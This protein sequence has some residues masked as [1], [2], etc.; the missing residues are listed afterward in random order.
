MS[1][2]KMT[3]GDIQELT[4]QVEYL[5]IALGRLYERFPDSERLI[6][7]LENASQRFDDS[8]KHGMHKIE[9][10]MLGFDYS[11]MDKSFEEILY[12]KMTAVVNSMERI[13]KY[14]QSSNDAHKKSD[15]AIEKTNDLLDEVDSR[16]DALARD[17]EDIPSINR[18]LVMAVGGGGFVAGAVAL[19]LLSLVT[20]LPTPYFATPEQSVLLQMVQDQA[21]RIESSSIDTL[22]VR[23][24]YNALYH[25]SNN[26]N[27]KTGEK[28]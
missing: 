10:A 28:Q 9:G 23:V 15:L 14:I 1:L 2:E 6:G 25:T 13:D 21:L 8:M 19:Y 26:T 3:V 17:A 22:K 27:T 20:W 4:N 11:S 24:D 18:N 7:R 5:I 12:R 16:I